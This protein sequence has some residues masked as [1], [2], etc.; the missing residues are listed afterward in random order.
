MPENQI[1]INSPQLMHQPYASFNPKNHQRKSF[2]NFTNLII[3]RFFWVV[4]PLSFIGPVFLEGACQSLSFPQW[5]SVTLG[6]PT[7]IWANLISS[8]VPVRPDFP[9]KVLEP[10]NC[11]QF[12]KLKKHTLVKNHLPQFQGKYLTTN[13]LGCFFG[14]KMRDLFFYIETLVT[15]KSMCKMSSLSWI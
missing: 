5:H 2:P 15:K 14:W 1:Y 4:P 10:A 9:G 6:P 12:K 13:L 7:A 8:S 3:E 11:K